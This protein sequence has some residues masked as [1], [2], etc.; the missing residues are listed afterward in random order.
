MKTQ[1]ELNR[2]KILSDLKRW[3]DKLMKADNEIRELYLELNELYKVIS[4]NE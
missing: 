1:E 3:A 4:S 2:K